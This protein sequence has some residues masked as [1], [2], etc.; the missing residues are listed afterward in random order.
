MAASKTGYT[1]PASPNKYLATQT[2][3]QD[4]STV[5]AQEIVV[6]DASGNIVG[7]TSNRLQVDASGVAVPVTD[8]GGSLT[9][10]GTVTADTELPAAA[11]L[12]DG[13]SNPTTP[14]VGAPMLAHNQANATWDRWRGNSG[15]VV[16]SSAARTSTTASTDQFNINWRGGHLYVNVSATGGGSITPVLQ[17]KD[18][19]GGAYYDFY[20]APTA[21]T[22]T[23]LAVYEIYPGVGAA[24]GGITGAYS[25]VLPRNWRVNVTHNNGSS[26]TYSVRFDGIV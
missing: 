2:F 5:H 11:A 22:S 6:C 19:T 18:N 9:V 20:T 15:V 8:N 3:T 12:A 25:R 26:I 23:G 16:L 1:E 14:L 17:G 4:S 7:V 24:A 21:L 13:A 10:D